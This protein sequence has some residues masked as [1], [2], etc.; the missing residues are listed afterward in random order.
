MGRDDRERRCRM[1]LVSL[2]R[3]CFLCNV[4]S[5]WALQEHWI[6]LG[7]ADKILHKPH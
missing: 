4:S 5:S 7:K 3:S 6:E 2:V 1:L